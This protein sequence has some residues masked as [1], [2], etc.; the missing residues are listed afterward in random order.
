MYDRD[1][2]ITWIDTAHNPNTPVVLPDFRFFAIIGTWYEG[3]IIEANVKNAYAQGCERV[4]LVDN[5]SPDNTVQAACDAG[6][7]LIQSYKT[8]SYDERLRIRNM[9]E[10]VLKVSRQESAEHIWW[11]WLD[12]D[13]FP[14]GPQGLTLKQYLQS[15]DRRFRIVG[16]RNY[17]HYP[18]Q[19]PY[20]IRGFHPIDFQ[21][22]C[23]E[24]IAHQFG[25]CPLGHWK[26][27]LHRYD[28]NAPAIISEPGFHRARCEQKPLFEPMQ[29]IFLNHFPYRDREITSRRLRTLCSNDTSGFVRNKMNNDR[30]GGISGITKRFNKLDKIYQQQW[31]QSK[32]VNGQNISVGDHPRHWRDICGEENKTIRCWYSPEKVRNAIDSYLSSNNVTSSISQKPLCDFENIYAGRR[33]FIIGNGPSLN[34]TD[35]TK[36]K[37]EITF[38]VNS[39]FYNFDKMGF[40]PT[41][42][43]V[44]DKLV[45]EDRAEEIKALTGMTK[46][47]GTELQYCLGG[48]LETIWANVIYDFRNYPGFPNFSKDAAQCLW[49]GGTVSYLCMQLAYYMGFSEVY[50]V[51][52]DHNYSVPKDAEIQGTVITSP[53]GDPN[54][55]HPDYFG[56]GKRWHDPR[57]DRMELAY[58]RAR[59]VFEENG[60]IVVNATVGGKL[61]VFPRIDYERL[62]GVYTNIAADSSKGRPVPRETA[63]G[64]STNDDNVRMSV[65][66][67]TH[68]N[69]T[70]LAHTLDS[71]VWQ[72]LDKEL[73]EVI[74]VDNNSQ[75]NTKDLVES[76][77]SVKYVLEE[78]LGLS[79]ARNA[80]IENARGDIIVFIDDDAEASRSWLD[81]LL[82]VYDSVADAWAVGGKVLPI[83]DALKPDWLTEEYYRSLSL[84]EWGE[85][86]RALHWP[87]RI[88]GTN[89]SFRKEAFSS[90]GNFKPELGRIGSLL[91]S[92][93]DT[94]IQQRI[95]E[96]GHSVYYTPDATV[97]HHVP[98]FRMTEEYFCSRS[99]GNHLSQ[100]LMI[101]SENG[102]AHEVH[103]FVNGFRNVPDSYGD[104]LNE[105]EEEDL[106]E[107][108]YSKFVR[109]CPEI[110]LELKV[111]YISVTAKYYMLLEKYEKAERKCAE[112]M[113]LPNLSKAQICK[114]LLRLANIYLKQNKEDQSHEKFYEALYTGPTAGEEAYEMFMA[115]GEYYHQH[116]RHA[117]MKERADMIVAS[118]DISEENRVST[119]RY[120]AAFYSGCGMHDEAERLYMKF[121]PLDNLENTSKDKLFLGLGE[122]YTKMG[123]YAEA[124]EATEKAIE[125]ENI[126][127]AEK[128]KCQTGLITVPGSDN[129]GC[130]VSK[131]GQ[132]MKEHATSPG[133]PRFSHLVLDYT[134]LCNSRC[135]YCG[136]WK[137]R[138]GPELGLDSIERT[139]SSLRSFGLATCYVTGGEPYISDKVVDIARLLHQYLPGSRISGATN[140][141]QP[142][143]IIRRIRK[144]LDIGVPVEVHVSINGRQATH[145]ATRGSAG[146]WK[147]AVYLLETLKSCGVP[148]KAAMSL[149]PQTIADIPY[150]QEFCAER[151]IGLIY[152]WVRQYARYGEVDDNYST[153]PEQVKPMLRRIEYVP[154]EFD[155]VGLSRRLV[156]TPDGSLYPCEVYHPEILL[157]NVNEDSLESI[158]N[159]SRTVSIMEMI[160]TKDC[161]WCQGAGESDGSP[162]WMLMDCYRRHSKQAAYFAEH[163][164]Q[165]IHMPPEQS[166]QVI[167]DILSHKSFHQMPTVIESHSRQELRDDNSKKQIRISVVV[168]TYRN[169]V[170]L[171]KTLDSLGRQ[172]LSQE[173]FE[174]IVVDNNSQDDTQEVVARYPMVRYILEDRLGLSHARNTG[175]EKARGDI[176]A[177]IDD[178]AEASPGWLQALIKIYDSVQDAWAVG[179]KVLPIWDSQKPGWLTNEYHRSLSLV[180]WGDN[181][182]ALCWPERIIGTNCSFRRQVF[183]DIGLFDTCLGRIGTAL[184]GNEDT[185]I[186]QRIHALDRLVYYAPE[187]VVCHHVTASRMTEEYFRRREQG[188][189]ISK[190]ILELRSQGN[191][192]QAEQIATE[193]RHSVGGMNASQKKQEAPA[194]LIS[195]LSCATAKKRPPSDNHVSTGHA[196]HPSEM[197]WP[198]DK[199]DAKIA[200]EVS[201]HTSDHT[202]QLAESE[203]IDLLY[204]QIR[205]NSSRLMM[206]YKDKYR[207]RRCVIMGNGPSLN[208]TD[209][210]LLKDEYTF[211]LNKIYLLFDRI[212]WRP[213]FYVCVNPFVI[214]QS[215]QQILN[216]IPGLKFLDFVSFKYL[217]YN[218]DTVHLLSLNGKGFS[219]DPYE[220]VFQMHTVTYVAMQL[221]YYMGFD[222]VFLVGVDHF[223]NAVNSGQ[224]DQVVVQND[225]DTD[226]FD[227]NYF[228]KGQQWNLPNLK[229]SEEGYRIAKTTFEK[230]NKKIYN[231]TVGGRLSVFDR[232]D[233]YG[234]FGNTKNSNL[235][236]CKGPSTS[237]C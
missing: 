42:Y 166:Q 41:F 58:K 168:C 57:T 51:G 92:F 215:G 160:S 30:I 170:L 95:A 7:I 12:A 79:Y 53:S 127:S 60:R 172:T 104:G 40:K 93:E 25:H 128:S 194:N 44:E 63:F 123:R 158:L 35:L 164:P 226:H 161:H 208:N 209:L 62:F 39:I 99:L 139:F 125:L 21:P 227:P 231:A 73:Y 185:E 174:V 47:F 225:Y 71:L 119:V 112:G 14:H 159:S 142:T 49:V 199:E 232:V 138:N 32:N 45:A 76:Y 237:G 111:K 102:Y 151:D 97:Y 157:G 100:I 8:Q 18:A 171:A 84:V 90:I 114:F 133:Q 175:V 129:K 143:Q 224:P 89:C 135:T 205:A 136:I 219:T 165:A 37:D 67:C 56:K 228:A 81:E 191:N 108:I 20:Y 10:A 116:D 187:A 83:W 188:T 156:I 113:S 229:G 52:F 203:R 126:I 145:D 38:G 75:D 85:E 131:Q 233:F 221:A 118:P 70:L 169:P 6:A 155:C 77:P 179:G 24:Y 180:E 13:E 4:Y 109:V 214:Q 152:S 19:Q 150:M 66:V 146:F 234:V 11:L 26:H 176:I 196:G 201:C 204:D 23:I 117:Q 236:A 15:L 94:E 2:P 59:Q 130:G 3:D 193:V 183:T 64:E 1:R 198:E 162:K 217:P 223:F 140:G 115:L 68:R 121:F 55:F 220:G 148:V 189:R 134:R 154:D 54:H 144:I 222:E 29:P 184:L 34:K 106:L 178:D 61:G 207:G 110:P 167:A 206:Q 17:N 173:S 122:L 22:L 72:S 147:K 197:K 182:R 218:E 33:A 149:M 107:G 91:L 43:V 211:G 192:H 88:I 120:F 46:I 195:S 5:D 124:K 212:D 27:P 190:A 9:N 103:Q 74:V 186:Q 65:V 48:S 213:S 80:G 50:L 181:A 202:A 69:P 86:T 230:A 96:M 36:L 31:H 132:I 87:D 141:I 82:K 235:H 28:R 200:N 216:E 16:A 98:A 101:L 105:S 177:F 210:S 137:S 153:W 163:F 78:K